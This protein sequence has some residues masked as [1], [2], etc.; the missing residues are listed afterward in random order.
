MN[1]K[2]PFFTTTVWQQEENCTVEVTL[3]RT[4]DEKIIRKV[5]SLL[6]ETNHYKMRLPC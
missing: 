5:S 2:R 6:Q 1:C 3:Y 4:K